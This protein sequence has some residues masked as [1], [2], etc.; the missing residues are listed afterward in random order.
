[1]PTTE[2]EFLAAVT[3]G[4]VSKVRAQLARRPD[5]AMLRR[6]GTSAVLIARYHGKLEVA[7]I[8]KSHRA[9]VDIFEAAAMGDADRVRALLDRDPD[10]ANAF[11]EDGFG[12]LGLAAFFGHEPVVRLLLARGARVDQVSANAMRVMPLHSATAARSVPIA[13]LL[14]EHG[15]PADAGQGAGGDF[16]PLMEAA[17]N[18]QTEMV[19]LLLEYG[20]VAGLRDEKGLTAADHARQS[21]HHGLAAR[22]E[23]RSRAS[24]A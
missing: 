3:S 11:A 23:S 14:L 1:M 15:A 12:P 19:E 4:D 13:R 20:A 8:L 10:L 22:L 17:L 24:G 16:T 5:L 9:D 7:A 21:G 18:G 6:G 2:D